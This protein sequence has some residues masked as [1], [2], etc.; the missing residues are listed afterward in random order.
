MM[1]C[2]RSKHSTCLAWLGFW[3]VEGGGWREAGACRK[4]EFRAPAKRMNS[5]RGVRRRAKRAY[6]VNKLCIKKFIIK[7]VCAARGVF[8]ACVCVYISDEE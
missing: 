3:G 5:S 6:F 8:V 1:K 4:I 7:C 2:T